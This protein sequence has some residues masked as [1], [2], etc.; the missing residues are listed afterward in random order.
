MA[1]YVHSFTNL[2][3]NTISAKG[4]DLLPGTTIDDLVEEAIS[5]F[6]GMW[7]D[8][9]VTKDSED[10]AII[11]FR[12]GCKILNGTAADVDLQLYISR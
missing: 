7:N 12:E 8:V 5:T 1:Y 11:N 3:Y 4:M 2:R 9:K 6:K 10:K